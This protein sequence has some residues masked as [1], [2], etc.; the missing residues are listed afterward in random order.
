MS[1]DLRQ[2]RLARAGVATVVGGF[3]IFVIGVFPDL[4]QLGL[5]PGI[6]IIQIFTFLLGISLMT[7]GAYMH[8]YATRHRA[9]APRLRE[10]VGVRLMAT[11]VVVAWACGLADVLGFGS[12]FGGLEPFL[13][14]PLQAE[15][16][17]LG[18]L[19]TVG[20]ILFYYLRPQR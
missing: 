12:H 8:A 19:I 5:T 3:F 10:E 9:L 2:S 16:V 20:G 6:G 15:G 7:L 18:V 13:F 11:G 17:G 1:H 4:I 14:G